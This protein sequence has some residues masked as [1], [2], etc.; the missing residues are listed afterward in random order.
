MGFNKPIDNRWRYQL[1]QSLSESIQMVLNSEKWKQTHVIKQHYLKYLCIWVSRSRMRVLQ[2]FLTF[3]RATFTKEV[4]KS[5]G[6]FHSHVYTCRME[7]E[8]IK[9]YAEDCI[10]SKPSIHNIIAHV[11]KQVI[12]NIQILLEKGTKANKSSVYHDLSNKLMA[13][14]D[15]KSPF[16]KLAFY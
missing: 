16:L 7:P 15:L 2:L 1:L 4:V 14:I 10:H 5:F 9:Y 6:F 8:Y 11:A 12:L 3:S 13:E